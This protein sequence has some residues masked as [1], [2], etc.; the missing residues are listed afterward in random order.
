MN[1]ILEV[2]KKSPVA[3]KGFAKIEKELRALKSYGPHSFASLNKPDGSFVQ[4]AGGR[5]TCVL[6]MREMPSA[7][8]WRA[9]MDEPRVPFEGLQ[10]LM[11]GGGRLEVD[12]GEILFIDDVVC[13]FKAFFLHQAFPDK[14]KWRNM[15][16]IFNNF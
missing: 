7:K 1:M 3:A 6:E 13:A 16:G 5:V 12:P 14:I 9:Y 4:V 8:L 11:F 10:T 15:S 2:E